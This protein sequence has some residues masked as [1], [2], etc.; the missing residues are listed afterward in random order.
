MKV[1]KEKL[2]LPKVDAA[3]PP[4]KENSSITEQIEQEQ[5]RKKKGQKVGFRDRKVSGSFQKI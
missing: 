5:Q 1:I 2:G 4:E 3:A